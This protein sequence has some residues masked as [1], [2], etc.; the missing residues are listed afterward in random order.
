[1]NIKPHLAEILIDISNKLFSLENKI[2]FLKIIDPANLLIAYEKF[3]MYKPDDICSKA[4]S[5]FQK[6]QLDIKKDESIGE[7]DS[8]DIEDFARFFTY[9]APEINEC[10]KAFYTTALSAL[11]GMDD[12]MEQRKDNW[13]LLKINRNNLFTGELENAILKDD[14]EKLRQIAKT[15]DEF[16]PD[17]SVEPA[18]FECNPWLRGRAIPLVSYAALCSAEKCFKFLINSPIDVLE[19]DGLKWNPIHFAIAGGNLQIIKLLEERKVPF[20]G[21]TIPATLFYQNSI[22]K[23][24]INDKGLGSDDT[25][26][27]E[28]GFHAA[29]KVNNIEAAQ[30]LAEKGVNPNDRDDSGRTP[31]FYCS[32]NSG[33]LNVLEFLLNRGFNINDVD[34][35]RSTPL[36]HAAEK[37]DF[38]LVEFLVKNGANVN[39]RRIRRKFI[40]IIKLLCIFPY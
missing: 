38:K 19:E 7:D 40:R 2:A 14:V 36:F 39:V 11:G 31:L 28:S 25:L 37:G 8:E 15:D 23:W 29:A 27:G 9:F 26:N 16:D 12:E 4:K 3:H 1:M 24:L 18:G 30:I 5:I 33:P 21:C 32:S 22:L 6:Y 20:D 10:D 34:D 13:K 17:Q 35:D